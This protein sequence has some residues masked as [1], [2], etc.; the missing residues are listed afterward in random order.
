MKK[1]ALFLLLSIFLNSFAGAEEITL[2]IS[3]S[4]SFVVNEAVNK[5]Q[6]PEKLKVSILTNK[7][8]EKMGNAS[9]IMDR[10]DV[11]II[12][13]MIQELV[14]FLMEN[15]DP[16]NKTVYAVRGSRNDKAL[17]REG[18]IFDDELK[19][20]YHHLQSKNIQSMIL[21]VANKEFDRFI[22]YEKVKEAPEL[23]LYHP[24][25]AALFETTED[26]FRWYGTT[27]AYKPQAPVVAVMTYTHRPGAGQTEHI[28]HVIRRLEKEGF[29]VMSPFGWDP[30][31]LHKLCRDKQ[32]K[33]YM[34]AILAF[35]LKFQSALNEKVF[36]TIKSLDVPVFNALNLYY[37]SI[38]EWRIDPA[39]LKPLEVGWAIANPE[40]SGLIEPTAASGKVRIGEDDS[41]KDV[42]IHEAI[43]E[44]LEVLAPRIKQWILLRK[45][46]N[47][48]KR[49]VI[50]IYNNS[51]GKQNI[52]ASYLNVINSL[53]SILSH[54]ND[55]GYKIPD[56]NIISRT[57]IRDLIIKGARNIGA[58]APGELEEFLVNDKV[59]RVPISTYKTWYSR[60][61]KDFRNQV[62]EQ[63]GQV[64]D[65]NI[66]ARDGHIII[67]GIK[68]GNI[69]I[70][71]EP[72][73]GYVA[74]PM[75]LY[76]SPTL[77]PHH[78]YIA[79]Y[80]WM[81]EGF[82][83][84]A[85]I[86]L[87]THG[88]HEWLPGKQAG[89]SPSC[90]PDVLITDIP[91]LYPYIVDDVGEGIQAKRRGRAAVVDHLIPAVKEGGLY[92]EYSELY[93]MISQYYTARSSGGDAAE[94]R[95]DNIR[96]LAQ[97]L[98]IL[99]DI[100]LSEI[101]EGSLE[102]LE[103]YLIE[104]KG[105][106]M[107]YGLHTFGGTPEAEAVE[108]TVNFILKTHPQRDKKN[109]L[110]RLTDSGVLE[111]QRLA[112][113]LEGGYIPPGTGNDPF[114]NPEAIPTGKNFYGFDPAKIPSKAAY[115]LGK[116][117]AEDLINR[118]L[119]QSNT[120][121]QKVAIV[122]W[123]TE[124]IRNE[125]INESTIL[126]LLGM[127]PKWDKGGRVTDVVPIPGNILKRP[128]IDVLIDA[129][130]LYRDLFPNMLQYMDKAIQKAM[131]LT[132]VENLISQNSEK[133]RADLMAKG[134]SQEEAEKSS[135]LRIFSERPGNY[136][137]RV[138]EITSASG[139][140][141]KDD[142]IAK[143]FE[144]HTG[145][146]YGQNLWGMAA[147]DT[148]RQNLS[149]SDV[150]LHSISSTVYGTM[151]NDDMFQYLGGLSM[152]IRKQSGRPPDTVVSMQRR[153]DEIK[154]ED[155]SRT[156]GREMRTRYLN[157]KWINGMK[158]EG[159]A[160]AREMSNFVEYLWG[161]Q[162]TTPFA[163]DD[164]K[165]R[166]MYQVYVED[167]YDL[168]LKEF[169]Q[170]TNPWAIQSIKAR[171]LESIRKH[172]WKTDEKTEQTLATEYALN[173]LENGI[174]CCDHT[175]NNPTLNQMVVN[176]LSIPGLMNPKVVEKFKL[177][178]QKATQKN[179]EEHT[180]EMAQV[181]EKVR[182]GFEK[183]S[184]QKEQ[185]G[186]GKQASD[187]KTKEVKGLKME[188]MNQRDDTTELTSSGAPW[189]AAMIVI[190]VLI[191][192]G[193]GAY[194]NSRGAI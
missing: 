157:P 50:L 181:R 76:H 17:E 11:I 37:S 123:A 63:W 31:V 141:E 6:G 155:L 133:I 167:K 154:V 134:Y 185:S 58:W 183:E 189:Y 44:N 169:F 159:Y 130:G 121:P 160:G 52:G 39:G 118:S 110:K 136:G 46:P 139:L 112:H 78:Q 147:Q 81:K 77:M 178:V 186:K 8:V 89:L 138:T 119:E 163:V 142:E 85:Q 162:V 137:N 96:E 84:D 16:K 28:D 32:G 135:K 93:A 7:D 72:S 192:V 129:S 132:D 194:F 38:K 34:D 100:G 104:M 71:P 2:M 107:P 75:K 187:D 173:V 51:P 153:P 69:M 57:A 122:L 22:L 25:S 116:R 131:V 94:L 70:M 176:I 87:G 59:I 145:Y 33:P 175:C 182:E 165:W 27:P 79:A 114:R 56:K 190:L 172:Y 149:Q 23:G 146:A 86:H 26:Y 120:Y 68:L 35:S 82:N 80:L 48:D 64:D 106:F 97:R 184:L 101:A 126:H 65:S 191:I 117:A 171:M 55:K 4:D 83:A 156:I 170:K 67:P 13:V 3:D 140:W 36:D 95:L 88:T 151:D 177:A 19:V 1:K 188:D 91:S 124:T 30:D 98:G 105:N 174:A 90:P 180:K 5:L 143:A 15:V 20:Y 108:E 168:D 164:K 12:D 62:E 29:N 92:K 10:T 109:I 54:L 45:K 125:G 42:F 24:D 144:K 18:V 148:L 21:K 150:A 152:A 127:K 111:N 41:K 53:H 61:P 193:V 103:Q 179:L 43:E 40:I 60:L 166:Q 14:D 9:E 47:K 74:D 161:W 128:R 115:E 99:R 66:M 113:G 102:K 73:R 158:K 49:V